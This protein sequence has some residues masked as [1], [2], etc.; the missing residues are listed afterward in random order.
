MF[1]G[2]VMLMFKVMLIVFMD[3][4]NMIGYVLM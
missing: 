1:I 3:D 2:R 4:W